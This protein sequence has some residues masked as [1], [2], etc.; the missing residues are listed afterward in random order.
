LHNDNA[1]A[2]VVEYDVCQLMLVLAGT[3]GRGNPFTKQ[4]GAP[5]H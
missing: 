2:F 4:C 3:K 1:K 5:P